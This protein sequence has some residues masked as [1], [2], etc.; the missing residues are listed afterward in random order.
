MM[1]SYI[2]VI[3]GVTIII[4]IVGFYTKLICNTI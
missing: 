3:G 4:L 2:I 1:T